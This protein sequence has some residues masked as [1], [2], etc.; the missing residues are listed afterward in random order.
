MRVLRVLLIEDDIVMSMLMT[1]M[2]EEMGHE[3]CGTEQ[4]AKGAIGAATTDRPDLIIADVNL[5]GGNGIDA[6]DQICL[7]SFVPHIFAS[8]D[9]RRVKELKP[10][11][12]VVEKPFT[13]GKMLA[14][15]ERALTVAA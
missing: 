11:A 12:V 4:T 14:A 9:I 6:L 2:L 5:A 15:I 7:S 8:G 3:V 13:Y 10:D 1:M